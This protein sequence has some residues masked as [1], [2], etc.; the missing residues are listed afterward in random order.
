MKKQTKNSL[1]MVRTHHQEKQTKGELFVLD[2]NGQVLFSC[3]TLELPWKDNE[4]QVSCIPPGRYKVVPRYSKKY[5]HHL[6]ILDVPDR[7]LILIHE[8]NY[9]RQLLGCI[10]VGKARIDIDGDGLIDVTSSVL[11][12]NKILEFIDGPSEIIIS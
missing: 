11:T 4:F 2:E 1:S 7:S 5:K 10:A 8:A 3:F 12:K 9:V 6:H